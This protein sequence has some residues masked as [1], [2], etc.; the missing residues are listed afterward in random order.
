MTARNEKSKVRVFTLGCGALLGKYSAAFEEKKVLQILMAAAIFEFWVTLIFA[1]RSN[2]GSDLIPAVF[3]R[4]AS[5]GC[6][7][8][9]LFLYENLVAPPRVICTNG[10]KTSLYFHH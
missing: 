2:A 7:V 8:A 5:N 10:R 3:L 1:D 9:H 4:H 6:A